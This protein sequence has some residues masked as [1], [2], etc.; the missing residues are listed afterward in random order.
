MRH[1][2]SFDGGELFA[3]A[4]AVA[5]AVIILLVGCHFLYLAELYLSAVLLCTMGSVHGCFPDVTPGHNQKAMCHAPPPH[6]TSIATFH[7]SL[8]LCK[9]QHRLY[10]HLSLKPA[11]LCK[12]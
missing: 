6:S 7:R 2:Q 5:A 11:V 3:A 4:T 9:S 1:L 10:A 8:H 12:I